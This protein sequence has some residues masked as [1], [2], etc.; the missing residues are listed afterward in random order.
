ML[1]MEDID[2]TLLTLTIYPSN[3]HNSMA[4]ATPL[5]QPTALVHRPKDSALRIGSDLS[6]QYYG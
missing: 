1:T 4:Q 3:T 5:C 6:P 2:L